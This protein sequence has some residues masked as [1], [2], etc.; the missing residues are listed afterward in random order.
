M[1]TYNPDTPGCVPP[2]APEPVE[3]YIGY[4]YSSVCATQPRRLIVTGV[5]IDIMRQH[6][7][8]PALL[9]EAHLQNLVWRPDDTTGILI[10]S[11]T[12]WVPRL[13][14]K[15]PAIIVKPNSMTNVRLGLNDQ[16]QGPP[17]DAQ[18][19]KHFSTFWTGSHTLFAI[20]NSGA[21]AEILASEI[22]RQLTGFADEIRRSIGL[23]QFRV[24]ELG[25]ISELEEA[26]ETFTVPVTVGYAYGENWITRQ[27]APR[28][29]RIS[30]KMLMDC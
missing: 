24:L 12:K 14:E 15:R 6:F 3:Q 29:K 7:A 27:Q 11:V 26:I 21:Q 9:D 2:D 5:F 19:N 17:V 28:I 16:R 20:G 13:T 30:L 18:G 25:P 1:S 10:E 23:Q 22:Q 8:D 4:M